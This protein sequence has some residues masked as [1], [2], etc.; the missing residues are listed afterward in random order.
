MGG[1]S[2]LLGKAAVDLV[3]IH[4]N[5]ACIGFVLDAD[6]E[7]IGK[8]QA[9]VCDTWRQAGKD[10]AL[11]PKHG[12]VLEGQ[13]GSALWVVGDQ[14]GRGSLDDLILE[15]ARGISL[16][17]VQLAEEF[18]E[19]LAKLTGHEFAQYR[20]KA[21]AGAIGQQF[22]AGGSLAAALQQREEWLVPDL[23]AQPRLAGLLEFLQRCVRR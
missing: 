2:K 18:I 12:E 7:G 23:F 15:A 6:E 5:I 8:R 11:Q 3:R 20:A 22:R 9:A 10:L 14:D 4:D 21:C 17:R 1:L 13:P 19:N 16:A